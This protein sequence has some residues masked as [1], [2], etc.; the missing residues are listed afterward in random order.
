MFSIIFYFLK[1]IAGVFL[2]FVL[3]HHSME[4]IVERIEEYEKGESRINR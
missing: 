3:V 2:I 1:F 4:I